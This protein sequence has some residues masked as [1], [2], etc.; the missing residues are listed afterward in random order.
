MK[1]NLEAL[2][3]ARAT[4]PV[5]PKTPPMA[6]PMEARP[7]TPRETFNE[8]MS[9]LPRDLKTDE[10]VILKERIAEAVCLG[11]ILEE[12]MKQELTRTDPEDR[13][14]KAIKILE[15]QMAEE[16]GD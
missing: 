14:K 16:Y 11:F 3:E 9:V 6:S 1:K 7:P 15:S 4:P 2:A 10:V 13:F 8:L 5:V 12:S